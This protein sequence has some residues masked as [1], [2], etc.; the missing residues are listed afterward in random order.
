MRRQAK[1]VR[2]PQVHAFWPSIPNWTWDL[3]R[4]ALARN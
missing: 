2:F 1:L 4:L 3:N